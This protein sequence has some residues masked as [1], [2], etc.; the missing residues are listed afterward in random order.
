VNTKHG[1]NLENFYR[2]HVFGSGGSDAPKPRPAKENTPDRQSTSVVAEVSVSTSRENNGGS[3]ADK[4]DKPEEP[5]GPEG[6]DRQPERSAE[7]DQSTTEPKESV[8]DSGGIDLP[9]AVS[10][11]RPDDPIDPIDP[12]STRAETAT[13][14]DA[15][16]SEGP[17]DAL[18]DLEEVQDQAGQ[19]VDAAEA[20]DHPSSGTTERTTEQAAEPP[21]W[22]TETSTATPREVLPVDDRAADH[23]HPTLDLIVTAIALV[24]ETTR[25]WRGNR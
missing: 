1:L 8:V 3:G 5:E 9:G 14:R 20:V 4:P 17:R 10:G 21:A 13:P 2:D 7:R 24:A 11:E 18:T 16:D 22:Q 12:D 19:L 23:P 25:K 6:A 15:V